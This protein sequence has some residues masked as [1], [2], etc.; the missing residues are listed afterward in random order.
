[1][2]FA[3]DKNPCLTGGD[4]KDG[5]A[6]R[7]LL[8][9]GFAFRETMLTEQARNLLNLVFVPV[10]EERHMLYDFNNVFHWSSPGTVRLVLDSLSGRCWGFQ[11]GQVL[12]RCLLGHG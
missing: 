1:A 10:G 2:T 11:Q 3:V 6:E 7:S 5:V 12:A 9:D 4:H 8:D